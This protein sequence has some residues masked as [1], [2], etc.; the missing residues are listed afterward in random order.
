MSKIVQSN[1]ASDAKVSLVFFI[2]LNVYGSPHNHKPSGHADTKFLLRKERDS[3]S[4]LELAVAR[5]RASHRL[6]CLAYWLDMAP[7]FE[8]HYQFQTK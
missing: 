6:A 1:K 2:R 8:S 5:S 4:P 3:T 7:S